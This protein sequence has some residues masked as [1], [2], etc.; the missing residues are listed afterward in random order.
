MK[1]STTPL[2]FGAV[3]GL[4]FAAAAG[5]LKST[6]QGPRY[7]PT[8][9]GP[10]LELLYLAAGGRLPS[11]VENAWLADNGA[12]PMIS[13]LRDN[14]ECWIKTSDRRMGF[15]R[16][17]RAWLAF[18]ASGDAQ[19]ASRARL[20]LAAVRRDGKATHCLFDL[21][22]FVIAIEKTATLS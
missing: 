21:P 16:A 15:I 19:E 11:P 9:L 12:G 3:D 13:A 6:D 2:T 17:N 14:D 22:A 20:H 10:L 4:A 1:K 18:I 8:S 7:L 5:R